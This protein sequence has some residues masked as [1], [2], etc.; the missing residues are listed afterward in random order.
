MLVK[1]PLLGYNS[2]DF[3]FHIIEKVTPNTPQMRLAR[4]DYWIQTLQSKAP[5]GLNKKCKTEP[6]YH[7]FMYLLVSLLSD[8]YSFS[9]MYSMLVTIIS[10]IYT[11]HLA[12]NCI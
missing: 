10:M 1:F 12:H 8:I 7:Y 4:E 3:K 5:N 2:W 9:A 6:I 11:F